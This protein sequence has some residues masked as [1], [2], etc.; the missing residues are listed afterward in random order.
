MTSLIAIA[1]LAVLS[2]TVFGQQSRQTSSS[3]PAQRTGRY[4][5]ASSSYAD[6]I[7]Q[8]PAPVVHPE[9]AP[10]HDHVGC[11]SC[12]S[13]CASCVSSC[14]DCAHSSC[15][16]CCASKCA[17]GCCLHQ[18]GAFGEWLYLSPRDIDL[19]Y[20]VPQDGIGGIG[21]VPVGDVGV[22]DHEYS[23]GFR[24]G[25]NA[26]I[27]CCSS[28]SAAFTWY[29]TET[30]DA[31]SIGAPLV[32]Q[33]LVLFPGTFNAGFTAQEAAATTSLD[34]QLAD[35]DYKAVLFKGCNYYVNY[36]AGLRYAHLDQEFAAV[37]PFAPPDGT[38]FV[39]T[40]INF[41]GFGLRFGLEGER[42]LFARS[43][44]SVYSKGYVSVL[45]GENRASY[46][47]VNQFN[48]IEALTAIH[49]DRVMTISEL[50]LGVAWTNY[51]GNIRASAGY[52]FSVWS[53][54]YSTPEYI[55]AVQNANYTDVAQDSEDDI[56]F[57]GFVG[58]IE[59]RF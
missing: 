58:R 13:G 11:S 54:I 39:A 46:I 18:S 59:Y 31:I 24:V 44:L 32:I 23:S 38:T 37:F 57:D 33:P 7:M 55:N 14:C 6:S 12:T 29:E 36:S 9:P 26:A 3:T 51:Q 34:Y 50:E 41:D 2:Q 22:L 4:Y 47:Q 25:Y 17:Y 40:D 52:Y 27:D 16:H 1:G 43:G 56:A 45:A 30:D 5:N 20:A 21:T 15:N 49:D 53:N 19:A 28:F 8:E 35:V 48:G 42:R 10:A